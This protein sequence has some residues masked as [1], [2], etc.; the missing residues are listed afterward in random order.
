VRALAQRSAT[1]AREIKALIGESVQRV[2]SGTQ[3]VESA[4]RTIEEIVG[5][6]QRINTLLVEIAQA[7]AE[8]AKGVGLVGHAVHDLDQDTQQNSALVEQS[9]A[10]SQGLRQQAMSLVAAVSSFKL[11]A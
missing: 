11:P 7:S 4:G 9:A 1:A 2:E 3:V 10:S 5:N 8:Q 6:A